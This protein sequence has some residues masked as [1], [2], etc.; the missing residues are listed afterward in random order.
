L[1]RSWQC[2]LKALEQRILCG[3][4]CRRTAG[5]GCG[6][7]DQ[8][9]RGARPGPRCLDAGPTGS[10]WTS[11]PSAGEVCKPKVRQRTRAVAPQGGSSP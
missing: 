5:I 3:C 2:W 11:E 7:E 1:H 6:E 4:S 8:D 10:S 9:Q